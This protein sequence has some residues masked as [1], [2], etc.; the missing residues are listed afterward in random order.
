MS[1]LLKEKP[2]LLS[3]RAALRELWRKGLKGREL[4]QEHTFLID[5][6]LK[7]RFYACKEAKQG[8][9]ALVALGG[10]GRRELFP[11]SDIDL[12]IL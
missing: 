8:G 2:L 5:S 4:L 12:L 10:Y 11:F 7:D 9:I 6:F 3:G 1:L